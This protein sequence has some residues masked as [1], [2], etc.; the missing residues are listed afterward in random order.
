M[1]DKNTMQTFSEVIYRHPPLKLKRFFD[2]IGHPSSFVYADPNDRHSNYSEFH[3]TWKFELVGDVTFPPNQFELFWEGEDAEMSIHMA[4]ATLE[5][6]RKIH[7]YVFRN[8][9]AVHGVRF[10][11]FHVALEAR[12]AA[13]VND[14]LLI[15]GYFRSKLKGYECAYAY[16]DY[17]TKCSKEFACEHLCKYHE[18]NKKYCYCC[19]FS[20]KDIYEFDYTSI[21][22]RVK[23]R[24][25]S[26][27]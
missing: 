20:D 19:G 12:N 17:P 10:G 25:R 26:D 15:G 22:H 9:F 14:R 18:T 4:P 13:V 7:P 1:T 11:Y 6:V 27:D 21:N 16:K 3:K 23:K 24:M 2:A 5:V 8:F